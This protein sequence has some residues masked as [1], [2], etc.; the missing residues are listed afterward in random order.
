M[1]S[2]EN[3]TLELW[4]QVVLR[5]EYATFFHTPTWAQIIV[6]TYPEFHI[7]TQ[8]FV[9]D[10]GAVAI[11]PM[12]STVERNG[13]FKWYESMFPGGYGGVIAERNLTQAETDQIFEQLADCHTVYIHIMGNPYTD[14]N[15]PSRY[16]CSEHFTH[17][18]PLDQGL[19]AILNNYRS[20]H[21]YSIKKARK[22]AVEIGVAESEEDWRAYYAAY[23]DSLA[24]WGDNTLVSYP[25]T[26]FEQLYRRHSDNIKLWVARINGDL[27]TGCLIF[28]HNQHVDYWHAATREKYYSY[29]LGPLLTT[30][31]IRDA[32]Q[33]GFR[34]Y[35]FNPSGR[36]KGVEGY[37]EGFGAQKRYFCSYEWQDNKLYQAYQNLRNLG[38]SILNK[39][40]RGEADRSPIEAIAVQ[41]SQPNEPE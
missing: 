16:K 7:A 11:V 4:S 31:I 9:L 17:V 6:E 36:L 22:L 25:Y 13:Y 40:S 24:R 21:K 27:A 38:K 1:K 10:D 19:D 41:A 20:G 15:L 28:Y 5:S 30:E 33:R 29:G 39:S 23:E 18:L 14:M 37:K 12:V 3:P 32:C 2:V 35:D 8:G 34:Y 26:L